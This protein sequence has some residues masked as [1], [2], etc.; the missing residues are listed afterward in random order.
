[1]RTASRQAVQERPQSGHTH[2][3]RVRT[4][5]RG[6]HPAEGRRA[7]DHRT[8]AAPV[9]IGGARVAGDAGRGPPADPGATDGLRGSL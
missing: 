8:R 4:G 6:G 1:E 9:V 2:P 3:S 7:A 5:W